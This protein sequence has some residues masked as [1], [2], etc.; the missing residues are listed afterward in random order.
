MIKCITNPLQ[1]ADVD[2]PLAY[3]DKH[4]MCVYHICTVKEGRFGADVNQ[5]LKFI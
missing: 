1:Y 2:K 4:Q 3:I 5:A